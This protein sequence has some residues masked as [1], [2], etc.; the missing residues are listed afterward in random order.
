[1]V[2]YINT[3]KILI[4][5]I[6]EDHNSVV[7]LHPHDIMN[8]IQLHADHYIAIHSLPWDHDY[9]EP[10]YLSFYFESNAPSCLIAD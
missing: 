9:L 4:Q 7:A 1:M 10:A 3:P 2:D 6:Q 8:S 5:S